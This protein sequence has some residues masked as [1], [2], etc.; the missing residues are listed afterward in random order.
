MKISEF[1]SKF[2]QLGYDEETD[3]VLGA[4]DVAGDWYNFEFEVE[5]EDRKIDPGDNTIAITINV[6]NKYLKQELNKELMFDSLKDEIYE[7]VDRAIY[8]FQPIRD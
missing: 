7:A 5:D 1:I 3:L 6:S 4:Y 8:K 2:E